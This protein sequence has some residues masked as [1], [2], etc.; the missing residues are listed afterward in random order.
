MDEYFDKLVRDR[1]HLLRIEEYIA[2]H[3]KQGALVERRDLFGG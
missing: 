3:A 2:E 1:A